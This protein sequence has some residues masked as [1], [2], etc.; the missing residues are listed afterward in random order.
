MAFTREKRVALIRGFTAFLLWGLLAGCFFTSV[1]TLGLVAQ[2]VS[3]VKGRA[4]TPQAAEEQRLAAETARGFAVEWATFD[5]SDTKDY[6][7]RLAAYIDGEFFFSP[8]EGVQRCVSTSV[9]SVKKVGDDGLYRIKVALHV[10]RVVNLSASDSV[11]VSPARSVVTHQ[12]VTSGGQPTTPPNAAEAGSSEASYPF[13][14][15]CVNCVEVTTQV[16]EGRAIVVGSPVLVPFPTIKGKDPG[17]IIGKDEIPQDFTVFIS[18]AL[19]LYYSGKNMANFVA[20]GEEIEPLG[21]FKLVSA[22]VVS[23]ELRRNEAKALVS[24]EISTDGVTKMTQ[25]VAVEAVK[26]DR[27]LLKRLGSW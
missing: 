8:P 12:D 7:E 14:K 25:T 1:R 9:L 13:W 11:S 21:G 3:Y 4:V 22:N 23:F 2:A 18:Q 15:D 6:S 5:G 24:A 16:V 20:P 17:A 10:S 19:D 26:K 27:W